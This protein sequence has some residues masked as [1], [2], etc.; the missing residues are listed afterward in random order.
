MSRR[1][2]VEIFKAKKCP[3]GKT[4]AQALEGIAERIDFPCT[5]ASGFQTVKKAKR[6]LENLVVWKKVPSFA[7]N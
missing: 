3:L 7:K 6:H 4:I 2:F 5:R 1:F